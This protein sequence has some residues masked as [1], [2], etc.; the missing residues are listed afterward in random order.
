MRRRT[1]L[2]TASALLAGPLAGCAH[3]TAVLVMDEV[4]DEALAERASRD[5]SND[6]DGSRIVSDA[7]DSGNA[8]ASGRSPPLETDRPVAHDGAYYT[9]SFTE[10]YRG[11]ITQYDI[12][13]DYN[14][15]TDT[16]GGSAIDY[17]DLPEVDR[18]ALDSLL[19]P[20]EDPPTSDGYD[21]GVGQ[22]YDEEAA[23]ASVLVPE[24]EYD[25]VVYEGTRYPIRVDDGREITV[26]DYRYEAEQ[27]AADAAE[28]AEQVRS[29]YR[30]TLSGLSEAERDIVAEAIEDGY[31]EGSAN[32]AFRSVAERFRAHEA[33]RPETGGGYWLARYEGT[34]YWSDLRYPSTS[35]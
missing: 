30:F 34:D 3:P 31:Y 11:E 24:Q 2:A 14:P 13:I 16:P 15:G 25:A 5:V 33:V 20:P 12:A 17:D 22:E 19:P 8:T 21:I 27:V 10:S 6:P 9:L 32:D 4:D 28:F 26:Y 35:G 1:L 29:E 18:E 23:E 7:V